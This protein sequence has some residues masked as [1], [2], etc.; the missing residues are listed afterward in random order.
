ML[1]SALK[2]LKEIEKNGFEAYIV[3]GYPRDYYLNK[4]SLDIDICTS[5]TPKDL[6][7]IFPNSSLSEEKYGSVSLYFNNIRFEITTYRKESKYINNRLPSEVEYITSF[8]DDLK[9]RDFTINTMCIN[10]NGE[11]IDLMGAKRDIDNKV[12]RMIGN[13]K[14]RLKEDSLRILRAIRFA[15]ILNFKIDEELKKYIKKY[16]YL[17]K[18]LSYYRKKSEL[19]KIFASCNNKYGIELIAELK[20]YKYLGIKNIKKI[21]P[22]NSLIG[23]WS[24]LDIDDK[25]VFTKNE[26]EMINKIKELMNYDIL[27]N[28]VLY[29][30][31][32]YIISVV[33]ELKEI[34]KEIIFEK[35][36][37]LPIKD[38]KEID[39][40]SEDICSIL[41][42]KPSIILKNIWATIE[43]EILNGNLLNNKEDISI[44]IKKLDI[45]K[46]ENNV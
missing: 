3:G 34:N 37:S 14:T 4:E 2:V 31:D 30:N 44:Y 19:D 16:G 20:L 45:Q 38:R 22:V 1:K 11:F 15:T 12:I 29:S 18:K 13:P 26:K 41:N 27:N 24:Q 25:Y 5:A 21:K 6:I 42:I 46:N 10:S 39:I 33:G 8:E 43:Q 9:R 40:T 17:L 35:Y 28:T 23:I 36:N 32:L 7:I